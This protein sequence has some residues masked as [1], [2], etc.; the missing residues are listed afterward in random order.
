MEDDHNYRLIGGDDSKNNEEPTDKETA[1]LL[2]DCSRVNSTNETYNTSGIN[3]NNSSSSN[4]VNNFVN[5]YDN[6]NSLSSKLVITALLLHPII[7]LIIQDNPTVKK[8]YTKTQRKMIK[9]ILIVFMLYCLI[10]FSSTNN[11][12]CSAFMSFLLKFLLITFILIHTNI[13]NITNF[14]ETIKLWRKILNKKDK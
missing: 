2:N 9:R 1:Y 5:S 6:N 3:N 11:P 7:N 12:G 8:I 14:S 13:F 4:I 10:G